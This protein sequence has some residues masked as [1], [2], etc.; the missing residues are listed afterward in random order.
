MSNPTDN[1]PDRPI[2]NQTT[3]LELT[4]SNDPVAHKESKAHVSESQA[5]PSEKKTV[6]PEASSDLFA[7][8]LTLKSFITPDVTQAMND[9]QLVLSYVVNESDIDIEESEMEILVRS[10]YLLEENK[11]NQKDEITFWEMHN[12]LTSQIKPVTI[13]SLKACMSKKRKPYEPFMRSWKSESGRSVIRYSTFTLISMILLLVTQIYW[14]IGS[15][16]TKKLEEIYHKKEAVRVNSEAI[17]TMNSKVPNSENQEPPEVTKAKYAL[18]VLRQK[19]VS[20][21]ELLLGWNRVWQSMMLKPQFEGKVATFSKYKYNATLQTLEKRYKQPASPEKA[22]TEEAYDKQVEAT[23]YT[24]ELDK[25]RNKFFLSELSAHYALGALQVYLLPLLYGLLGAATYVLR[26]LSA[27]IKNLTY[28][29]DSEIKYRLRLSLG[30]LGGMVIG[31]FFKP[32]EMTLVSSLS[33]FAMAFLAGYHVDVLFNF[34]D[35]LIDNINEWMSAAMAEKKPKQ[36]E[37]PHS[38]HAV[39]DVHKPSGLPEKM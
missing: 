10:K 1:S 9:T 26:I 11:W 17:N 24:F 18:E 30:A 7:D 39:V 16:L 5:S 34:M 20:N 37:L 21:L 14:I 19:H 28:T 6:Y 8:E 33:P 3:P 23:Q 4:D 25:A 13:E 36:A 38:P 29:T 2:A 27:E 32:D 22:I 35:R 12:N 31:W 15:D